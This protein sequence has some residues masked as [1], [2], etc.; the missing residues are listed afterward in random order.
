MCMSV[1]VCVCVCGWVFGH[2]NEFCIHHICIFL[3]LFV[4]VCACV[5]VCV[6]VCACVKLYVC[7]IVYILYI[8]V[9]MRAYVYEL[10]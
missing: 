10:V 2:D 8:F 3:Y 5:Y 6:R 4:R 9:Y 1:C 7:A